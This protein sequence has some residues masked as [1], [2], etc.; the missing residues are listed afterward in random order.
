MNKGKNFST[1]NLGQRRKGDLYETPYSLTAQLLA[2]E[3]FQPLVPTL[4]PACGGGAIVRVL[5]NHGFAAVDAYDL[6]RN[7]LSEERAF[8]QIITNPPFSQALT[9]ILKAKMQCTDRFA[10]LLPLSYL[11]GKAR[12]DQVYS[13]RSFPLARVYVFCRYPMLGDPLREDG[14]YRTGMMVYAWFV[15]EKGWSNAP[16][17]HWIDN[18]RYVLGSKQ[19]FDL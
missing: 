14:R 5:K 10:F 11:H 7:F 13:D 12:L 19:E 18:H 6:E 4:E 9:F 1:N 17:I 8:P 16:E 2:V 15:W 3:P